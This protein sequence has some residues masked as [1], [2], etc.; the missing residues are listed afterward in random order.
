MFGNPY[1][2]SV[3]ID[4]TYMN[5][6]CFGYGNKPLILLPG[7]S[8]GL[9]NV[10]GKA[11]ILAQPYK[12][13]FKEY[14]IYMFSRKDAMPLD[15]SIKDMAFDQV[16]ALDALGIKKADVVGISEGGMI[17][18]SMAIYHGEYINKLVIGVSS[19]KTN[20][21]INENIKKWIEL[22]NN[23]NH[24]QLMIDTAEKTYSE[25]YLKKF[26]KIYP[27]IGLIGK[28]KS[29][30]RFLINANA[31]LNFNEED[32]LNK[33]NCPTLIIGGQK[34]KTVS[35]DASYLMKE[36]IKDSQIYIYSEY[37]HGAYEEAKD[38]N[39]KINDFLVE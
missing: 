30:E 13:F 24:K 34:D 29:Y 15:Y 38:F 21:L 7:L 19:P 39:K 3:K 23:N 1:N 36:K 37:G 5:Y 8:D 26:R 9:A 4:D 16:K 32:N 17:A 2:G 10:K 11:F 33:I 6:A 22:V 28:P 27:I 14:K 31:I 12:M 18:L 20:D 35:V 25:N